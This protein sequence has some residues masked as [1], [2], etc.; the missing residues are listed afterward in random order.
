MAVSDLDVPLLSSFCSIPQASVNTL[1]D[2][3]TADLVQNLLRNISVKIR[4]YDSLESQRL[5]SSVELEAAVRG[6]E[7][8]NK[9]LKTQLERSHQEFTDLQEKLQAQGNIS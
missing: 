4:E 1:L 3:P 2:A 8:K 7:T 5:R 9:N 6:Q